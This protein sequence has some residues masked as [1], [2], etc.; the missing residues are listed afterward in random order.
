LD[1]HR[2]LYNAALQER[3]DADERVVRRAPGYFS[4]DRAKMP[5]RDS[6]QSAQLKEIRAA[7]REMARWSFSSQQAILRRL[8]T[9]FGAFFRRLTSGETP[10]SP[11]VT[12][13]HRVD[14]VEWPTDGDGCRVKPEASRVYL[15]GV[16]DVKVSAHRPLEGRVK[17]IQ[18]RREGRKWMRVS[19]ATTWPPGPWSRPEQREASTWASPAS[20]SP[21]PAGTST[22]PAGAPGRRASYT[23]PRPSSLERSGAR[24]TDG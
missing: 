5:V 19:P 14:S 15:Q 11:R 9:A 1:D 10:D 12:A 4:A 16:G 3:R 7:N 23:W 21:P 17:T 2:E 18:I 8:D 22:T 6:T 24:P 13:A 20:L